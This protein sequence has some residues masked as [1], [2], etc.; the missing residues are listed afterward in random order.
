MKTPDAKGHSDSVLRAAIIGCGQIAG[1]DDHPERG[2]EVRTH[3]KAYWLHPATRLVAVADKEARRAHEFGARWGDV[4]V[5]VDAI[6]MVASERPDLVSI[7]T[8]DDTHAALLEMCVNGPDI[9]AVWCEKPL[10]TDV[11]KAAQL[12]SAYKK[13]GVLLAVNYQRRWNAEMERIKTAVRQKKLGTIQKAV[14]YYTKGI[15]HNGSHAIDLLLDWFGPASEMQVLGSHS[16]FVIGDPTVDARLL[17]GEVP[18]YLIGVDGREYSLFEIQV[19]GTMGRVD[20]KNFGREIQWFFR[21]GD[22]FLDAGGELNSKGKVYETGAS[23]A[24]FHALQEIV[25]AVLEGGAVRSTGET[26]LEA[27]RVCSELAAQAV[28]QRKWVNR[29][30]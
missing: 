10:T 16:D 15:C 26:A 28:R 14:V 12:V 25:H 22:R 24:M 30:N 17:L 7:C 9:R 29:S 21:S 19:L 8:P 11:G 3:A 23:T 1:R 6:E 2:E 5:Y 18:V 4:S 20:V 27:L 13:R